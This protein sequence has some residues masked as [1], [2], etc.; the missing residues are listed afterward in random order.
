MTG[1]P[2]KTLTG[3]K[4]LQSILFAYRINKQAST[5]FSH[6][7]MMYGREPLIPWQIENNLGPLDMSQEL[8][9][10]TIEENIEKMGNLFANKCLRWQLVT[11]KRLK[12][13]KLKHTMPSML[14]MTLRWVLKCGKNPLWNT[15]QKP[16]KKG[17]MW[18]GLY[19]VEGKTQ[20]GNY[21]LKSV[22][23]KGKGKVKNTAIPPNQLKRYI[24]RS[25]N[26][27]AKSDNEYAS[28]S[29]GDDNQGPPIGTNSPVLS[30]ADTILYADS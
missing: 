27:P 13:I 9:E 12:H 17:P 1:W 23:G 11:S 24:A 3:A 30:D 18:K 2:K 20:A 4:K 14:E 26:I 22:K 19:K 15:K 25:Q 29:D 16:L 21:L 6:F 5:H 28:E 7:Y 10:F 8:P